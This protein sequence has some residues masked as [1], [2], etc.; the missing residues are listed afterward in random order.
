M[1]TRLIPVGCLMLAVL[2]SC[3]KKDIVERDRKAEAMAEVTSPRLSEG[4]ADLTTD[5]PSKYAACA[6][7][8]LRQNWSETMPEESG[9]ARIG[10]TAAGLSVH[11]RFEDSDIFSTATANQQR[12]WTLGDVVEV[13]VKPG[14]DRS[15]YWEV[16][17]TPNNFLM[18]LHI[19]SRAGMQSGE[20]T[21]EDI[22]TP[23]SGTTYQTRVVDGSWSAELTI[24]WAAFGLTEPPASGTAWQFAVCRYNYN[25]GVEE[26][27]ELSSTAP[28]TR[29]S[30]HYYEDYMD[31]KF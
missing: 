7:L 24:P 31:L 14:F 20:H 29:R 18:D 1:P 8:P 12:M 28:L 22:I 4:P 5:V 30:Y 3:A 16:H 21:W 19:P 9:V 6:P 23:E 27:P 10:A 25:G 13:F 11:V 17:V 2:I 26:D 15:D